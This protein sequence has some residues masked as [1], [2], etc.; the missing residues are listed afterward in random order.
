MFDSSKFIGLVKANILAIL[1]PIIILFV[2][3]KHTD[4]QDFAVFIGSYALVLVLVAI[5][6]F[7]S[8]QVF[9]LSDDLFLQKSAD[10]LKILLASV[11]TIFYVLS[12]LFN[13]YDSVVLLLIG[14]LWKD[15]FLPIYKFKDDFKKYNLLL[16]WSSL[17]V[18]FGAALVIHYKDISFIYGSLAMS[19][20]PAI[21]FGR[22]K[23]ALF[24]MSGFKRFVKLSGNFAASNLLVGLSQNGS[25]VLLLSVATPSVLVG[26]EVVTKLANIG[27][28]GINVIIDYLQVKKLSL[29]NSQ[30]F[31]MA[32]VIQLI[33]SLI[34]I[35]ALR[36][37]EDY[38]EITGLNLLIQILIYLPLVL[39][40]YY[41]KV[42]LIKAEQTRIVFYSV[43]VGTI[44]F[45]TF[46]YITNDIDLPTLI[47]ASV[48][49]EYIILLVTLIGI[50]IIGKK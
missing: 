5:I 11:A 38:F 31:G 36:F 24:S 44:S 7:G 50:Q 4:K 43:A 2:L 46:I 28:Y 13:S 19:V 45:L 6:D 26:Y 16:F 32:I 34:F 3:S 10:G 35:V 41:H 21:A 9:M 47:L 40:G 33:G 17:I 29:S 39:I 48:S 49:V 8:R 15:V 20:L 1:T 42:L 23:G 22:L 14:L 30:I 18:V 25:K 27:R 37:V 12:T